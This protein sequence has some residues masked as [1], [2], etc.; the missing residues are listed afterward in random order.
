MKSPRVHIAA[1][2]LTFCACLSASPQDVD[3]ALAAYDSVQSV[4]NANSFFEVLL[5]EG[6][7]DDTI[8]FDIYSSAE[9]INFNVCYWAAE[10]YN[11]QQRYKTAEEYGVRALE[12]FFGTPGQKA[13][14]LGLLAVVNIR[15]GQFEQA[16]QYVTAQ[17]NRRQSHNIGQGKAKCSRKLTRSV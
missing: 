11:E 8:S 13:D 5:Q 1:L 10:W 12:S 6:L 3:T 17:V 15:L 9:E 4:S 7:M 14:A 2:L 16:A